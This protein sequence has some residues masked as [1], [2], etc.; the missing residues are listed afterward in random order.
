MAGINYGTRLTTVNSSY[1]GSDGKYYGRWKKKEEGGGDPLSWDRIEEL[2]LGLLG[3]SPKSLYSLTFKEFGNAVRGKKESEE[4][5]ER[6]NWERTR[7]QSALL[8][9]VH[10]KKGSKITP[11]DLTVFPWEKAQEKIENDNRGWDMFKALAENK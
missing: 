11:K 3:L 9:N 1:G 5:R 4:L 6:S 2:G 7:W 8:L 10:T